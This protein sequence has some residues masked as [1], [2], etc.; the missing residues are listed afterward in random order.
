[1]SVELSRR[2]FIQKS[3][4]ATL[5]AAAVGATSVRA[6]AKETVKVGVVGVG[7][8]GSGLVG[9]LLD[10]PGVEITAIGDINTDNLE[11]AQK[12]VTDK[13][14]KKPDGYS[15]GD[16]DFERLCDRTDLDA[17]VTA[18]P[19]E[20]HT[21]V[22]VAAMKA[23][24][25]AATEVPAAVTLEECWQLVETSEKTGQ[26]CMM[27]ENVNYFRN[28]MMILMIIRKGLFGELLHFEAGYQ[29]DV[30]FVKFNDKGNLLWR[31]RH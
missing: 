27:M 25:Y 11:R 3:G 2:A 8:R 19:W 1:M 12:M 4:S 7:A 10:I 24:K 28:V 16:R 6:Q 21:P 18:T 5:A 23:G 13:G 29:H 26:P 15:K 22:A 9:I 14:R 20:W 30:R 31:G 17:V